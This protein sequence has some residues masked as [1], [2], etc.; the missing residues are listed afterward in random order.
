MYGLISQ[1]LEDYVR[2]GFGESAWSEV[3]GRAG[4]GDEDMFLS[5]ESYPDELTFRLVQATTEV[6]GLSVPQVLEAFG[7]HWVLYTAQEGYGAML[8]MFGTSLQ[9]F[10]LNLDNLHSHVALTFPELRP[11]SFEVEWIPGHGDSLLLHYRSERTGLAPMVVGLLR[12]LGRRFAQDVRV[13]QLGR[14]AA[15]DHDVFRIDILS[16]NEESSASAGGGAGDSPAGA[17]GR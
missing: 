4:L 15:D 17:A 3:R 16:R 5:M 1:A 11:P 10:L 7:E 8:S 14:G 13:N 2:R 12:G 9:Q 6:L